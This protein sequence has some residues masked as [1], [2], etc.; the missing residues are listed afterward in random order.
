MLTSS[1]PQNH[2]EL[3]CWTINLK[4][5]QQCINGMFLS[6]QANGQAS[7]GKYVAGSVSGVGAE[8]G[9]FVANHAY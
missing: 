7:M 5:N 9:L 1:I 3:V 2:I 8:A 6:F 4:R